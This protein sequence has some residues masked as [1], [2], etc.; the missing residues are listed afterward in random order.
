MKNYLNLTLFLST[1]L[2][3]IIA[4][5]LNSVYSQDN[6]TDIEE[7]KFIVIQHA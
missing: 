2:S 3:L 1:L 4:M 5:S 7:P 6:M